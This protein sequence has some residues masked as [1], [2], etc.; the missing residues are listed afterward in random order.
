V[1]LGTSNLARVAA[2]AGRFSEAHEL[3]TT[4]IAGFKEI[5]ARRYVTETR[6][7]EVECLV[8]EGRYTEALRDS[9]ALREAARE[10]R[11]G[12][13]EAF[14]LRQ[15]GLARYQARTPD[16]AR[17][18]LLESLEIARDLEAEFEVALTLRAMADT[19]F[20]HAERLRMESDA[21]L[22]RL[23]VV[24]VPSVPLP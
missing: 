13:L 5:E 20:E 21:I 11:F 4:A 24:S 17:P 7:R 3:Y 1:A 10:S 15:L 22:E 6:V 9:D 14:I 12:G 23:G 8:F 18:Q 2:R 19:Q 16:E